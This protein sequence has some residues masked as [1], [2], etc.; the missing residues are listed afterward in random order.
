MEYSYYPG[1][2]A[3]STGLEFGL[4]TEATFRHLGLELKE[5]PDWNCCGASSAHSLSH[6]LGLTLPARNLALAQKSER[7]L[8][9]PCAACFNRVKGADYA[10]RTDERRRTEIEVAV[11][12]VY[13]GK[14]AIRPILGVLYE[15]VGLGRIHD[16]VR[17]PLDG[18]KV[19]P[20]YGCLLVRP[21]QVTEF[22]DPD[23][24]HVMSD[25][26]RS[27]GAEVR[28]W[29][30]ATDCCGAGLS[31]SRS[32][33]VFGLVGRLVERAR[34]AGADAIVSACPLCQM[35]LEMRQKG[36]HKLPAFY[37]TELLALA[38]GLPEVERW[39]PKH[40]IDPR[41][42]LRSL[43]LTGTVTPARA[44]A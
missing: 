3:H 1:C 10:L 37:F 12:F 35:N 22:D 43:G 39:W 5:I 24:P 16:E 19:V 18:L 11:G 27:A 23:D 14:V 25:L 28:P 29:S 26:L 33:V 44:A 30:H 2:S 17:R 9:I 32:D 15:D 7:D 41:P 36:K 4:S 42:L 21:P 40:L 8:V 34:E 31:L 20:Y 13:T 6:S 38:F